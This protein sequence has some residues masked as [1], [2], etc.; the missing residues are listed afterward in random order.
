MFLYSKQIAMNITECFALY[1]GRL[2]I[3]RVLTES[4]IEPE[5]GTGTRW[6]SHSGVWYRS[7]DMNSRGTTVKPDVNRHLD[8][9]AGSGWGQCQPCFVL[10]ACQVSLP[11]R[12]VAPCTLAMVASYWNAV[13]Y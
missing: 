5:V 3:R 9:Q 12:G 7:Q 11:I 10:N 13:T 8:T 6:Q 4:F 2:H 1:A